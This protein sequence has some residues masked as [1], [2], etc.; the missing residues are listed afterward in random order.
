MIL[1]ASN[2]SR[3]GGVKVLFGKTTKPSSPWIRPALNA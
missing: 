2:A 3:G 1:S